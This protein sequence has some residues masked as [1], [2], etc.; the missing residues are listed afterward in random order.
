VPRY[1]RLLPLLLALC[2]LWGCGTDEEM[3][4][5][6]CNDLKIS[7]P[8]T[9]QDLSQAHYAEGVAFT[10]GTENMGICGTWEDK[11]ALGAYFPDID[12][13]Q[14]AELFVRTNHLSSVVDIVDGIPCFTYTV[15]GETTVQYLCGI[16]ETESN[17]WVVQAY[18]SPEDFEAL[19]DQM[20]EYI[21]SVQVN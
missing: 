9:F 12:V 2:L 6:T 5:I 16:F 14:Y 11:T 19:Y 10:F 1:L 18:S 17:F 7:L 15:T 20:W 4:T 3:Q 13:R 21:A 8:Q